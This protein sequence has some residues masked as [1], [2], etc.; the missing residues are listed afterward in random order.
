MAPYL[1]GLNVHRYPFPSPSREIHH[2]TSPNTFH[3]DALLMSKG[4][5]R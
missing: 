5:Y 2:S 1:S 4:E 3:F